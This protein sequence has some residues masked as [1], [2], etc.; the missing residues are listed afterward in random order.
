MATPAARR[1]T[2]PPRSRREV[3][4]DAALRLFYREG[5][6][7]TGID[8]IL[9]ESGV[10]KMTLYHH[11]RSKEELILAALRRRHEDLQSR[12]ETL[13]T[14]GG[15][16]RSRLLRSFEVLEAWFR[17]QDGGLGFHGCAFVN[18]AAEYGEP[19]DPIHQAAAEHKR[20][21]VEF[22]ERLA[23]EAGARDPHL[24][25]EQIALLHE[26][27]IVAAQVRGLPE[28]AGFARRSHRARHQCCD[29]MPH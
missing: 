17:G 19:A 24:L 7:A 1:K 27:A 28:A 3:L 23:T 22:F 10:A 11:F 14:E 13:E 9:A 8:R 21:Q 26:G 4:V 16:A 6:H 5:F 25:A 12:L 15:S 29:A 2:A 20:L 18:A